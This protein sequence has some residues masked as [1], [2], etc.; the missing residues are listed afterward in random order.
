MQLFTPRVS[1][2]SEERLRL[3]I[4]EQDLAKVKR[5]QPWKADVTDQLTGNR[6]RVRGAACDAP[7]CRCDAIVI[8]QLRSSAPV[9]PDADAAGGA[10]SKWE[11]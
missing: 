8:K 2:T 1:S 6:Y 4:N 5:G 10:Q 9:A 7:G 3:S 11:K